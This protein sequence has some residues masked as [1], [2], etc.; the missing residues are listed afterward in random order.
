VLFRLAAPL[1]PP[2]DDNTSD[3]TMASFL[4]EWQNWYLSSD[5]ASA[6][7]SSGH[8]PNRDPN[9]D[10]A[11]SSS[12]EAMV[13]SAVHGLVHALRHL[14]GT[15]HHLLSTQLDEDAGAC[16]EKLSD[17]HSC[18]V[19][20]LLH[21]LEK[22]PL[23]HVIKD[24]VAALRNKGEERGRVTEKER[25]RSKDK[26]RDS[27]KDKDNKD[28]ESGIKEELQTNTN[29]NTRS[30][31]DKDTLHK[32]KHHTDIEQE[33]SILAAAGI[34]TNRVRGCLKFGIREKCYTAV[35][36]RAEHFVAMLLL[37]WPYVRGDVEAPTNGHRLYREL[38][39]QLVAAGAGTVVEGT[40]AGSTAAPALDSTAS[41][42]ND[43]DLTL[44]LDN[45]YS[46]S[47]SSQIL[48]N[49]VAQ[50]RQ[51]LE[52][53]LEYGS[54]CVHCNMVTGGCIMGNADSR[55]EATA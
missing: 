26:E 48:Q 35:E 53:V 19:Q 51:Q 1:L 47:S 4:K 46:T 27:C 11:S 22:L 32:T 6:P 36:V 9:K 40:A 15:G 52:L 23:F 38:T 3:T 41:T 13:R 5:P 33:N 12:S 28:K 49:E 34:T 21:G 45:T 8:D 54:A 20:E 55:E 29:K 30:E 16:P 18:A 50:L 44:D 7:T 17:G 14:S 2:S 43:T 39:A 37:A 24:E 25:D 10:P 42:L 31:K